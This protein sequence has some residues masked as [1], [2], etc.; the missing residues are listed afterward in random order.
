MPTII[1]IKFQ[2]LSIINS[3]Q[4]FLSWLSYPPLYFNDTYIGISLFPIN[5]RMGIVNRKLDI[6]NK[7]KKQKCLL[8]DRNSGKSNKKRATIEP[9][10]SFLFLS[11]F[12]QIGQ[13]IDRNGSLIFNCPIVLFVFNEQQCIFSV[14][15]MAD[16]FSGWFSWRSSVEY[17]APLKCSLPL[18]NSISFALFLSGFSLLFLTFTSSISIASVLPI[19]L[20]IVPL[21][22]LCANVKL[23][24]CYFS[25]HFS[26]HKKNGHINMKISSAYE[27]IQEIRFKS[28]ECAQLFHFSL[29]LSEI[30]KFNINQLRSVS[31][32]P[33]ICC[34][35]QKYAAHGRLARLAFDQNEKWVVHMKCL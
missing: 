25:A 14:R 32:I 4:F 10:T 20:G 8:Q 7:Q 18:W 35:V 28:N 23:M 11:H 30:I 33:Y 16:W 1:P 29:A 9:S 15:R 17:R 34:N 13:R 26:W 2:S 31:Y 6:M 24:K 3:T 21:T 12:A 19:S 27:S 22:T 5:Q